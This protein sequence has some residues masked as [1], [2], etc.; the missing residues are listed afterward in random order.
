MTALFGDPPAFYVL[1]AAVLTIFF[2]LLVLG[3]KL[4]SFAHRLLGLLRD[5]N[6][7]QDERRER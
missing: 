5:F 6:A 4:I 2:G 7:Y 1:A 3:E